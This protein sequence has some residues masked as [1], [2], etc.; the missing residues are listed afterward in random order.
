MSEKNNKKIR[1]FI[2]KTTDEAIPLVINLSGKYISDELIKGVRTKAETDLGRQIEGVFKKVFAV[3]SRLKEQVENKRFEAL[4]EKEVFYAVTDIIFSPFIA[5]VPRGTHVLDHL[6][7]VMEELLQARFEDLPYLESTR[8]EEYVQLVDSLVDEIVKVEAMSLAYDLI[9]RFKDTDYAYVLV[10]ATFQHL[11]AYY[12]FLMR[13][14]RKI[15]KKQVDKYLEI[16][17]E[18]AGHYEKFVA[19]IVCLLEILMKQRL[20]EYQKVRERGVFRN[21]KLIDERG[22]GMF[23]SSYD[24]HMRNAIA[25]KTYKIDIVTGEVVFFDRR[26]RRIYD[27][28]CVQKSTRELSALLLAL[29][30]VILFVFA[31]YMLELKRLLDD[32]KNHVEVH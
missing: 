2:R 30:H 12:D 8:Y 29:P 18:L 5:D 15:R 25:H 11:G 9:W 21:M 31:H 24:R 19:L 1:G 17:A 10:Q 3:S 27:F 20:P 16:Y 14:F 28:L 13:N 6:F 22:Y 4:S 26:V 32:Y 23:I 7:I